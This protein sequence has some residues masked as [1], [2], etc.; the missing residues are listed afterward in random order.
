M[1]NS[2]SLS[3]LLLSSY[4]IKEGLMNPHIKS[5]RAHV[6]KTITQKEEKDRLVIEVLSRFTTEELRKEIKRR[7]KAGY[8]FK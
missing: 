7:K 1:V 8:D 5:V 2:K 6:A 4:L 3:L